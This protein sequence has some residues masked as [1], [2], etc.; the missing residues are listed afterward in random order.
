MVDV[1]NAGR[2]HEFADQ[3]T[4]YPPKYRLKNSSATHLYGFSLTAGSKPRMPKASSSMTV[5]V[6]RDEEGV[7]DERGGSYRTQA[8]SK[9]E[10]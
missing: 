9:A 6:E 5:W 8:D 2:E 3:E 7:R 1:G 10:E 4:I